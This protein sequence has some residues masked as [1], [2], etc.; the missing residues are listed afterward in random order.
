MFEDGFFSL[1]FRGTRFPKTAPFSTGRRAAKALRGSENRGLGK[2]VE[3]TLVLF[4]C[5]VKFFGNLG[6]LENGSINCC[7]AQPFKKCFLCK[8]SWTCNSAPV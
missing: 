7:G 4:F 2:Q 6:G 1:P 5:S 3:K 8:A